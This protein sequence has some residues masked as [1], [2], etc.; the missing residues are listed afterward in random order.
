MNKTVL[1][2]FGLIAIMSLVLFSSIYYMQTKEKEFYNDYSELDTQTELILNNNNLMQLQKQINDFR[3]NW[4]LF[5]STYGSR[6][7]KPFNKDESWS[8]DI[9]QLTNNVRDASDF[10][11]DGKMIQAKN[12]IKIYKTIWEEIFKRNNITFKTG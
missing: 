12:A 8:Y 10:I 5:I 1:S 9:N 6:A 2:V 4:N 7:V 11:D 3:T